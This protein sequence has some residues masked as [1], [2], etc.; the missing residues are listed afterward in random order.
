[1]MGDVMSVPTTVSHHFEEYGLSIAPAATVVPIRLV[2]SYGI[3][4]DDSY[5]HKRHQ[6]ERKLHKEGLDTNLDEQVAW[7]LFCMIS[8]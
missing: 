3:S 6:C 8:T 4:D 7:H 1:M 2:C 5:N